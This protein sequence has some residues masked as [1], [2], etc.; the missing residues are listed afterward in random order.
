MKNVRVAF[1]ILSKG[2]TAPGGYKKIS[3]HMIFDIKMTD[4]GRKA[5][6]VAGGHLTGAPAAMTYAS[7][8]SRETI[9]I[10]LTIAALNSLDVKTGDVMNAYIS[11]P[12]MEK[13]WTILGPK[14]GDADCGLHAVIVQALYGLKGAGA[15]FHA[16]LSSFMRRM[17]FIS[18]KADPDLWY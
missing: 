18:C 3:C 14:F 1:W 11:A 10:A 6:L 2:E 5:R 4:F 9:R 12:V 8:V 7:V 17:G 16:H 15:A 13:V